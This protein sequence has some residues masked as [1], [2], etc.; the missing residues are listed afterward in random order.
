[1]RESLGANTPGSAVLG[2]VAGR[3][4]W[5]PLHFV[6][7]QRMLRGIKERAEG[8]PLVPHMVARAAQI[9][10]ALAGL[11]LTSLF[12]LRRRGYL[13]LLITL[14]AVTP[15]LAFTGDGNAAMAGFLAVGLSVIGTLIFGRGWWSVYALIVAGVRLILVLTPDAYMVLGV[16]F[17]LIITV[18]LLIMLHQR[19]QDAPTA[20]VVSC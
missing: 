15:S 13:W 9:G 18:A 14:A 12:L 3:L 16:L 10:W 19:R 20:T 7:V 1:M 17:A 4:V 11:C 6:M 2:V 8:Q 5:D